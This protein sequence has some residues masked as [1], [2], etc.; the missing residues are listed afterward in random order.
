[1]FLCIT[2]SAITFLITYSA[3]TF[4]ISCS[5]ITYLIGLSDP[6]QESGNVWSSFFCVAALV[7]V[8]KMPPLNR[9]GLRSTIPDPLSMRLPTWIVTSFPVRDV[10]K[11][12]RRISVIVWGCAK[13]RGRFFSN[14][15][16]CG[17]ISL[18]LCQEMGVTESVYDVIFS[19]GRLLADALTNLRENAK[20]QNF[21]AKFPFKRW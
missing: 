11:Y 7:T 1:M 20:Y 5:A 15:S 18:D 16:R 2:C 14:S 10:I 17:K 8:I 13:L 3:I 12:R 6:Q 4:V 19:L 21:D 9:H